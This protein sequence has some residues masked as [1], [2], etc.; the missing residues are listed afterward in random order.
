M[1]NLIVTAVF[2]AMGITFSLTAQEKT[3]TANAFKPGWYLGGN[4][5]INTFVAEG[6]NFITPNNAHYFNLIDNSSYLG[7]FELGYKFTPVI[8]LRGMLGYQHTNW[9]DTRLTQNADGSYPAVKFGSENLTADLLVNLSNWFAGY[10]PARKTDISAFVGAGGAY[11][12]NN[13]I[14]SSFDWI[15]R[16]GLQADYHLTDRLNLN[17]IAELNIV[18]DNYNDYIINPLPVDI[19][20]AIT[21]GLAYKLPEPKEKPLAVNEKLDMKLE[22]EKPVVAEPVTP[23]VEPVTVAAVETKPVAKDTIKETK[24]V[25]PVAPS[26]LNEKI[27]FAYNKA[28]IVNKEQDE[29]VDNIAKFMNQYPN[30]SVTVSG[31]ADKTTGT[32]EGNNQMS[33][34]RAVEVANTL[35]QKYHISSKRIWVKWYGGG[36]QPFT[37]A[38]KNRLVI[39]KAPLQAGTAVVENDATQVVTTEKKAAVSAVKAQIEENETSLFQTV[40]FLETL[41]EVNEAKQLQVIEKAGNFLKK[42]PEVM[43][44]ISGYADKSS[45]SK[46]GNNELSKKRAENVANILVQKYGIALDRIQVKW[47]GG[48]KQA[49]TKPSMNK[50]VL[51]EAVK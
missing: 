8:G 44:M 39:V 10:N 35:I 15:G 26:A 12:N 51:I 37:S 2:L 19:Y 18:G 3:K 50:I 43:V 6:N 48:E 11:L 45:G 32:V 30:A 1:R 9:P 49:Y 17:V 38:A 28:N 36:V 25:V 4:I 20:S 21:V 22:E 16:G 23:K 41:S 34:M 29:A 47:F 40:H 24:V 42:N 14:Y 13:K 7:R 33:K 5:G 31:Y 46:D 27:F